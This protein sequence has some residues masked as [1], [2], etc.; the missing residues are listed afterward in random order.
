MVKT[1]SRWE[2]VRHIN[3]SRTQPS[4]SQAKNTLYNTILQQNEW[5]KIVDEEK[6][7]WAYTGFIGFPTAK[8]L[9]SNIIFIRA[10]FLVLQLISVVNIIFEAF[11]TK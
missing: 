8:S 7:T 9:L 5:R 10:Y 2:N 6:Y 1:R 4:K 11:F 3:N